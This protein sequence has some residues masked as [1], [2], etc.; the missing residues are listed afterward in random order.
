MS[1]H[2]YQ[3]ARLDYPTHIAPTQARQHP[4]LHAL[5]HITAQ[6]KSVASVRCQREAYQ[7]ATG[8][9]SYLITLLSFPQQ[10]YFN[11]LVAHQGNP[12]LSL[13]YCNTT[14]VDDEEAA[15]PRC[16]VDDML[17]PG[18]LPQVGLL[19]CIRPPRP[20]REP[21]TPT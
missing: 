20:A 14:M 9:G 11:N 16:F 12:P 17:V 5:P 15:A 8:T 4:L 6:L 3:L 21:F 10:P 7:N 1:W 13:F 19:Y 18:D 2:R